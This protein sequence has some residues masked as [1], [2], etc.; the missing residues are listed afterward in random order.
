MPTRQANS[1]LPSSSPFSVFR[2][3]RGS[4][5]LS[6]FPERPAKANFN[7]QTREIRERA[8]PW[9]QVQA[10][11][12]SGLGVFPKFLPFSVFRVFRSSICF[13][14]FPERPAN[15][16]PNHQTHEKRERER[17]WKHLNAYPAGELGVFPKFLPF[18]VFRVFRGP[19]CLSGFPERSAKANSN[20]QTREIRERERTWTQ[21]QAS[22]A[23]ELGVFPKS[24]AFSV[25]GDFAVPS[26]SPVP[27]INSESP[28]PVHLASLLPCVKPRP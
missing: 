1:D 14:G 3:F 9:K 21:V 13:S 18:S 22:P 28:R 16:N 7:H 10:S 11:P 27:L 25:S 24:V 17:P 2:V 15:A 26:A 23:S 19:I 12:A 6:G 8:R 20:H 4:I 5:C